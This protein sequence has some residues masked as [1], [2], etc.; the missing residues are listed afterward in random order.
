MIVIISVRFLLLLLF[1]TAYAECKDGQWVGTIETELG[2]T[3]DIVNGV[4]DTHA[5]PLDVAGEWAPKALDPETIRELV[6]SI[7]EDGA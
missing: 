1:A 2:D 7:I 3:H 4:A 5:D 6:V